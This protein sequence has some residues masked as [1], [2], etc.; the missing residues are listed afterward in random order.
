MSPLARRKSMV[1]VTLLLPVSISDR[2]EKNTSCLM[3]SAARSPLIM[4][5]IMAIALA[6]TIGS[7][8]ALRHRL[9]LVAV[10]G[11]ERLPDRHEIIAGIKPFRNLADV[12]AER[13]AVAQ[14]RRAREHVDLRAGVVD[15]IFAR[16]VVAGKIKQ[17]AQRVAEHRAAAMADMHRPGRIG[18]D[19]FDIDLGAVADRA[20]A[21]SRA[22]AQH[23]AAVRPPRPRASR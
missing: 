4:S 18:R 20:F 12:L 2:S 10:L 16:D 3:L 15:V 19:V 13:F 23:R 11:R 22:F 7:H 21:V 6:R 5:I 8:D 17:A 14:E 9:Q 1:S